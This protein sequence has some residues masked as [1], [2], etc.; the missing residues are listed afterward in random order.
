MTIILVIIPYRQVLYHDITI[1]INIKKYIEHQVTLIITD[2]VE[3][4]LN[5]Q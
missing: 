4:V 2:V 5:N 3:I 1:E